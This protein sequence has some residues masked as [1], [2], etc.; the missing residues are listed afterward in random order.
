MCI[1][2]C[3]QANEAKACLTMK[4][5]KRAIRIALGSVPIECL[6]NLLMFVKFPRT[7]SAVFDKRRSAQKYSEHFRNVYTFIS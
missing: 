1:V 6:L 4:S 2:V 5:E 7:I 3:I